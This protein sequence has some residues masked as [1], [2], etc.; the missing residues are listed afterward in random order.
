MANATAKDKTSVTI[1]IPVADEAPVGYEK[2]LI[3]QGAVSL[4]SDGHLN[5]RINLG[6]AEARSFQRIRA[7]LRAGHASLK[8]GKPVFNNN[9][10]LR[11]ICQQIVTQSV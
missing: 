11:W 5:L 9:D 1:T 10:T 7:A 6:K 8:C 3:E 2:Q 4:D